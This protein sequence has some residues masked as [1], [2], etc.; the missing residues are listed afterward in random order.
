MFVFNI[1]IL[2]FHRLL[3]QCQYILEPNSRDPR[4]YKGNTHFFFHIPRLLQPNVM[5]SPAVQAFIKDTEAKIQQGEETVLMMRKYLADMIQ[6]FQV[7]DPEQAQM[8]LESIQQRKQMKKPVLPS[9]TSFAISQQPLTPR[10]RFATPLPKP[11]E[12]LRKP[13]L[14]T[15]PTPPPARSARPARPTRPTL[16]VRTS[17]MAVNYPDRVGQI[18][19]I[20]SHVTDSTVSSNPSPL[21]KIRITSFSTRFYD[22]AIFP[23]FYVSVVYA[24]DEKRVYLPASSSWSVSLK[25]IKGTGEPHPAGID[26]R[27]KQYPFEHG[28]SKIHGLR[29]NEVSSKNGG[30][31]TIEFLSQAPLEDLRQLET[32]KVRSPDLVIVSNRSRCDDTRKFLND[33]HVNRIPGIGDTYGERFANIGIKTIHDMSQLPIMKEKDGGILSEIMDQVRKDKGSLTHKKLVDAILFSKKTVDA[34]RI[35]EEEKEEEK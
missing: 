23:D 22:K 3:C 5:E 7:T 33:D 12:A 4:G 16:P 13:D 2:F 30:K 21:L 9:I 28:V 29:F 8:I 32:F 26:T 19:T 14:P 24:N 35:A 11:E 17:A 18:T 27:Y 20:M 25:V 6:V 1:S 10:L 31:Y 34:N 15:P